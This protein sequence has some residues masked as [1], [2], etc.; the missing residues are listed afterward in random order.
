MRSLR[1]R[2]IVSVTLVLVV[3]VLLTTLAL[4]R[5]FRDA[6]RSAREERLLAQLY[7]LMAAAEEQDGRLVLPGVL[8]EPRLNLPDSGLTARIFDASGTTVWQSRSA[9]GVDQPEPLRLGAGQ[10]RVDQRKGDEGVGYLVAAFGVSWA[11]GPVPVDYTF[12]V[13]EDL[14]TLRREVWE[15]RTSLWRWLGAMSLLMLISL[16]AILRW[17]LRPLRRV[18]AEVAAVETGRQP[19]ILGPYP[20]ELQRLTDNLNALLVQERARQERLDHA[21]GDLAHSL[22][23]PLAV[24]SGLVSDAGVDAEGG[25]LLREQLARMGEIVDYQLRRARTGA[26]QAGRLAPQVPLAPTVAR[27]TNSLAK[28]YRDK[29]VALELRLDR[30]AVF[31]GSEADLMDLLGNLLDNAYKW[32]RGRVRVSAVQGEGRLEIAVED[33]GPGID[34]AEAASL[35]ERGVRGDESAPGHGIGLAVV[36]QI[37]LAYGGTIAIGRSVL[38]GAALRLLIGPVNGPGRSSAREPSRNA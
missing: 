18:A 2:L 11:T 20:S 37:A 19:R 15:F 1:A 28:V 17:G 16:G 30:E 9:L 32:C 10:F 26:L 27:L 23:T 7:L 35:L 25:R 14:A 29:P 8:A 3:T 38:G 21:L 12:A 34:A 36:R 24:M 31:Q 13:A 4:E 33:D 22:K 5:A 6:A